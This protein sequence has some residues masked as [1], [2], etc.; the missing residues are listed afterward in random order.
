[1]AAFTL[2]T[3]LLLLLLLPRIAE[4]DSD[5]G[6][7]SSWNCEVLVLFGIVIGR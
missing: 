2:S 6:G 1:L 7:F 4:F 5:A 3:K